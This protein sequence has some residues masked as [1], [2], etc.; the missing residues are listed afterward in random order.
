[1]QSN[2]WVQT[3]NLFL[4]YAPRGPGL[5]GAVAYLASERDVYGWFTGPRHDT[6]LASVFFLIEDFH[7]NRP[8]RYEAVDQADLH[9]AWTLDEAR[10]HEIARMQE[11]FLREWLFYRDDPRGAVELQAYAQA[12]LALGEVNVRFERLAKFSTL[13]PNWTYFSPRFE[14]PVLRHLAKRWPLA[15]A[16]DVEPAATF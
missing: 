8:T 5:R 13:Q 6:S 4:A 7:T 3:P 1:L 11:A 15:Y 14:R 2:V 10:R 12:E 16:F 9:S